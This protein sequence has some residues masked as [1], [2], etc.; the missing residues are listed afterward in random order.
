[1][2]RFRCV[3]IVL[4]GALLLAGPLSAGPLQKEQ[5]S[6]KAKWLVHA[7]VK[8]FLA[9][10]TGAFVLEQLKAKGLGVVFDN[11]REVFALDVTKDLAS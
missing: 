8:A 5:V 10:K 1:M 2:S 11:I 9:S 7:D 4:A 6:A 3:S